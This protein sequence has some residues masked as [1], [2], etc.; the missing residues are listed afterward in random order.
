MTGVLAGGLVLVPLA[1]CS[2][3]EVVSDSSVLGDAGSAASSASSAAESAAE[4]VG[5]AVD[6]SGST[7]SVTLDADSGEVELL[8]TTASF[9]G[10]QDGEATFSVAGQ[11]VS[12][13][14]GDSVN[15]GP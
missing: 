9:G 3:D 1:G 14:E 12:C 5:E 6:C 13:A 10:V 7:C 15:A 11:E 8:G 2:G 4:S